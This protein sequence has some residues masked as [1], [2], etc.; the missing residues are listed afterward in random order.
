M[1]TTNKDLNPN[2]PAHSVLIDINSRNEKMYGPYHSKCGLFQQF[3]R[4]ES[5]PPR[6]TKTK[7]QKKYSM[8]KGK[9]NMIISEISGLML[10]TNPSDESSFLNYIGNMLCQFD[11]DV[12]IEVM[13][14]L[15]EAG[16]EEAL[17]IKIVY[18]Y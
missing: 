13:N 6:Y 4:C 1:S 5:E 7:I 3:C 8:D 17:R 14:N 9:I 10:E 15:G 2:N 11:T 12:A 18:G 16:K